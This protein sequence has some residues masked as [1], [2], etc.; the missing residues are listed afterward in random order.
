MMRRHVLALPP[1]R[2]SSKPFVCDCEFSS[3][4]SPV[5]SRVDDDFEALMKCRAECR[6]TCFRPV[7]LVN[8]N[9]VI[10]RRESL[11]R[12]GET[13]VNLSVWRG[14]C[15]CRAFGRDEVRDQRD[16]CGV[17]VT[18]GVAVRCYDETL[19]VSPSAHEKTLGSRRTH[20]QGLSGGGRI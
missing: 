5:F 4:A 8:R 17:V 14:Q 19:R 3:P 9:V 6:A 13:K 2:R 11:W 20:S 12:G 7:L 18:T 16:C 1:T 10:N 15:A